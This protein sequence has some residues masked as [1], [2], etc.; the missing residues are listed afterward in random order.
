[1]AVC[2]CV[3]SSAHLSLT[4]EVN[5]LYQKELRGPWIILLAFFCLF[6]TSIDYIL[7]LHV[8]NTET[9][10]STT[11]HLRDL[12]RG[13]DA[14]LWTVAWNATRSSASQGTSKPQDNP[15]ED[16]EG[17]SISICCPGNFFFF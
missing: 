7:R 11:L 9:L 6:D 1:M 2:L 10:I 12:V 4:E 3:P 5:K 14:C 13:G 15:L 17:V 16:G 8:S